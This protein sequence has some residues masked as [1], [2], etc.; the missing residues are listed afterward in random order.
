MAGAS[1]VGHR[2]SQRRHQAV[3]AANKDH[4][5]R[6][7]RKAAPGE[8]GPA[9]QGVP[10]GGL[11][12]QVLAKTSDADY[13]TLWRDELPP[14][15]IA[16]TA[17]AEAQGGDLWWNPTTKELAIFVP[18][19]VEKYWVT[20]VHEAGHIV[21]A[22]ALCGG[23]ASLGTHPNGH[24]IAVVPTSRSDPFNAALLAASGTAA[25][26]AFG[27]DP[28]IAQLTSKYDRTGFAS[29][30]DFDA[31]AALLVPVFSQPDV[32][33]IV[34]EIAV[35]LMD[36]TFAPDSDIVWTDP[37]VE[38]LRAIAATLPPDLQWPQAQ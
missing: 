28:V 13:A 33:A 19:P 31:L 1:A 5:V 11:A 3:A 27:F 22:L 12:K 36:N 9:G 18:K 17:P 37:A 34:S 6:L 24:V 7:A 21:T 2:S 30:A 29:A 10:A 38:D 16:D 8:R 14:V 32:Q 25:Q 20:G 4:K 35:W 26:L 23:V 15:T